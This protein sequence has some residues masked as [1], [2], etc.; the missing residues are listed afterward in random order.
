MR[1]MTYSRCSHQKVVWWWVCQIFRFVGNVSQRSTI[2]WIY[3]VSKQSLSCCLFSQ[4][5]FWD[6]YYR[7]HTAFPASAHMW[8]TSVRIREMYVGS[9][10]L[11]RDKTSFRVYSAF[12]QSLVVDAPQKSCFPTFVD[13]LYFC[14]QCIVQPSLVKETTWSPGF[15][16][17]FS[18]T[19]IKS[20]C[21]IQI[22]MWG[23]ARLRSAISS[24]SKC[25]HFSR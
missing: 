2:E 23:R 5:Q 22:K 21:F 6:D 4:S 20:S 7:L 25:W 19:L 11:Y 1:F 10:P 8:V 3:R 15:P 18:L 16:A 12:R 24:I 14:V 9:L 13:M 17:I